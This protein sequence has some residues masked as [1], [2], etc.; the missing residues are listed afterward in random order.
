VCVC[1]CVEHPHIDTHTHIHIHIHTHTNSPYCH[2]LSPLFRPV[3]QPRLTQTHTHKYTHTQPH[4]HIH[5]HSLSL[6]HTLTSSPPCLS[7]ETD[8][9]SRAIFLTCSRDNVLFVAKFLT[10]PLLLSRSPTTLHISSSPLSP[11]PPRWS[12]APASS[13]A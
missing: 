11:A 10:Q 8:T 1:V 12:S 2:S 6:T 9:D 4:T 13:L 5:T 3:S 7:G